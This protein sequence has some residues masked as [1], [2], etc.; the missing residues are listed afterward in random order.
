M[1]ASQAAIDGRHDSHECGANR[2]GR[3]RFGVWLASDTIEYMKYEW[4][5][6]KAK[7][8]SVQTVTSKIDEPPLNAHQFSFST[9]IHFY[10]SH[11]THEAYLRKPEYDDELH[12]TP[13]R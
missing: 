5:M 2:V 6:T 9:L 1:R 8:S 3:L 4:G 13:A 11:Y 7:S 10:V 12:K